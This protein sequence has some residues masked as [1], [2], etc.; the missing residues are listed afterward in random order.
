MRPST[1]LGRALGAA[2]RRPWPGE[3]PNRPPTAS[4]SLTGNARIVIALPCAVP[5]NESFTSSPF[6]NVRLETP[7]R[8]TEFPLVRSQTEFGN[9]DLSIGFSI[10]QV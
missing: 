1:I 5:K 10:E 2:G 8:E 3:L 6:G 7:F 4:R 9:E